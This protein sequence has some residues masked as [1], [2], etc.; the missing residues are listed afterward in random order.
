M[1]DA[2]Q[3]ALITALGE[4]VVE[5]RSFA[6]RPWVDLALVATITDETE[7][8]T[9]YRYLDDG[10]FEAEVPEEFGAVL[11]KLGELRTAM[12]AVASDHRPWLQCLLQITRPEY[13]LKLV[14]E[15]ENDSRWSPAETCLDMS[16]FAGALRPGAA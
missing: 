12:Q 14:F 1:T 5:D 9:G 16:A 13:E 15:Y 8:I 4:M 3:A 7:E 11:E 10:S 2:T 6:T